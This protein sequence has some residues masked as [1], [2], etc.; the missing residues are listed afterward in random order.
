[1]TFALVD[2]VSIA[3][4]S[5]QAARARIF[6]DFFS[7]GRSAVSDHDFPKMPATLEMPV[8]ILR[9]G[10]RE[11][12]IDHRMQAMQRNGSV[13]RLEIG[14]APDADRAERNAT[15]GQL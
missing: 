12:P 5:E 14:A 8:G 6:V 3:A 13:H 7:N 10:K 1:M 9:I 15:P 2:V 11:C 4:T